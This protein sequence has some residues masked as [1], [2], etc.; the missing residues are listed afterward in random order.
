MRRIHYFRGTLLAL[1]VLALALFV[2]AFRRSGNF[3]V[4]DS[5]ERSDAIV[6]TQGDSL[7]DQYWMGLHL[8]ADGY[9]RDLFLDAHTDH[10][11]FGRTQA[12]WATDF[13]R[14]TAAGA[15]GH[16]QVC[17]IDV[18]TTAEEAY[19][20]DKCLK[21]RSIRSALIVVE[22]FHSRRSLAMFSHLLPR[23]R[24]SIAPVRDPSRFG[25]MWWRKRTWIRTAVV[26][27]QH[28]LWWELIDRWRFAPVR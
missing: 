25:V 14:K 7:D 8:L 11:F 4:V 5:R 9:G 22:D 27:W 21:G 24:W 20:V 18:D 28:L 16:T 10:T 23:Y 6:I 19:E 2:M 13:I 1:A 12:E 3:L 15:S 17:P 26:E